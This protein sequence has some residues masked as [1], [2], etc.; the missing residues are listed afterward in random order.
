MEPQE[1]AA[2]PS[3]ASSTSDLSAKILKGMESE[4]S[5]QE[6]EKVITASDN[7]D[8]PV[9][10]DLEKQSTHHDAAAEHPAA[11]RVVTAQDWT[12]PNDPENPH[13]WSIYKKSYHVLVAGL[14][15]LTMYVDTC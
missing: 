2:T 15:A 13:N 11:T 8:S 14:F 10:V 4:Q 9:D 5:L 7:Q 3:R 12:G 1:E 6:P